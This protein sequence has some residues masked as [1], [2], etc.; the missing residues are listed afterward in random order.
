MSA[1]EFIGTTRNF[2]YQ[3]LYCYNRSSLYHHPEEML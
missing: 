1:I 2:R 3:A